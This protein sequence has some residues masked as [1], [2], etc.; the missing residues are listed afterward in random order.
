AR[1]IPDFYDPTSPETLFDLRLRE[2]FDLGD[3]QKWFASLGSESLLFLDTVRSLQLVD[4]ERR[5]LL[6]HHEL[7]EIGTDRISLPGITERCR[8]STL[9]EPGSGRSWQRYEIQREMPAHLRRR[10]K[11]SDESTPI[12]V[13][14]PTHEEPAQI[15]AGLSLGVGT[16]IPFSINA[17]FDID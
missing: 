15:Y 9:V 16:G 7:G 3:F 4:I 14:L 2:D 12:A 1:P 5:E 17:Q 6:I 13:A 11:A 8:R 10:H